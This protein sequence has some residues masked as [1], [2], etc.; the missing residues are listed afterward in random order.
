MTPVIDKVSSQSHT[1]QT[2][3]GNQSLLQDVARPRGQ[4]I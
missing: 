3:L 2:G 1:V 4:Q